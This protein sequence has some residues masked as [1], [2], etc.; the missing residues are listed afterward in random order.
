[1][2]L[3]VRILGA[4]ILHISTEPAGDDTERGDAVASA[5]SAPATDLFMGFTN[6]REDE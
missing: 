1:M 3:T 5:V 4:E 6:G 2:T